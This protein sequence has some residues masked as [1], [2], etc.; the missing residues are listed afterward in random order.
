MPPKPG[1]PP[2]REPVGKRTWALVVVALAAIWF[3]ARPV[4]PH[5]KFAERVDQAV[6]QTADCQLDVARAELASL[7]TDKADAA[8]VKR[9]QQAITAAAGGCERKRLHAKAWSDLLPVLESALQAGALDR[10]AARL[11]TYTKKWGEDGD[12]REWDGRI[13][14]RRAERLLDEADACLKKANR[15]CLETKL[16]AAERLRR[17]EAAPR[18]ALL[19]ESLSRLLEQTVLEQGAAPPAAASAPPSAAPSPVLTTSPPVAQAVQKAQKILADAERELAHGNYKSAMDKADICATMIDV[20]NREC[21]QLKQKAER[22]NR[23]ML[24]CVA[25]GADWIGDRCQ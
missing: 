5:K 7:K 23:D 21:L 16:D 24:R 12:T 25:S 8:Q 11:D 20:G 22:L 19:R 6:A 2:L 4:D 9:L 14:T 10:A 18:I 3:I 1:R 13:D 15:A 17:P